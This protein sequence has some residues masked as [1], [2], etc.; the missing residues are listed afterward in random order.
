MYTRGIFHLM[1]LSLL[2]VFI[3]V[4]N[5][6][7]TYKLSSPGPFIYLIYVTVINEHYTVFPRMNARQSLI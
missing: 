4:Y 5:I 7:F 3:I 2:Y 1:V 6:S